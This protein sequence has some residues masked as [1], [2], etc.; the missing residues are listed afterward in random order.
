MRARYIVIGTMVISAAFIVTSW[1]WLSTVNAI[2]VTASQTLLT[3]INLVTQ[4]LI[5]RK[6]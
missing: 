6:R 2:I 5:W 1:F 4:W 3:A